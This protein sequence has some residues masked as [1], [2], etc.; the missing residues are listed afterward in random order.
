[1]AVKAKAR[2]AAVAKKAPG[3]IVEFALFGGGSPVQFRMK[4]GTTLKTFVAA[5]VPKGVNL[6][7]FETR[8]NGKARGADHIL[9]DQDQVSMAP[10]VAGGL[11]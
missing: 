6:D 1:M 4:R 3:I 2:K 8:V 7:Q 11:S 10:I 5:H 9:N